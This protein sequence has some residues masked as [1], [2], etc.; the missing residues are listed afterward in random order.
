[1]GC[2]QSDTSK[3]KNVHRAGRIE[4]LYYAKR[5]VKVPNT[6]IMG[7]TKGRHNVK[8]AISKNNFDNVII[9]NLNL[10]IVDSY[11][12][13]YDDEPPRPIFTIFPK[14]KGIYKMCNV[15]ENDKQDEMVVMSKKAKKENP[16]HVALCNRC[17]VMLKELKNN[18]RQT[19]TQQNLDA[20]VFANLLALVGIILFL[21]LFVYF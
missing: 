5:M 6:S 14:W 1:M 20:T 18:F 21:I 4:T 16:D 17:S 9:D 3:D 19:E 15:C 12:D 10:S 2:V 8:K 7:N 11:D 13:I